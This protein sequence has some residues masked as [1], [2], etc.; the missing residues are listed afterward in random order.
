LNLEGQD[1]GGVYDDSL[2]KVVQRR[3]AELKKGPRNAKPSPAMHVLHSH[4]LTLPLFNLLL[5]ALLLYIE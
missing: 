5:R 1:G 4:A 3:Q 2:T